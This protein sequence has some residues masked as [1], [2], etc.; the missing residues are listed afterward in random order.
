MKDRLEGVGRIR[1]L[2]VVASIAG[3]G[4]FA[5][6]QP[7]LDL[8]G[9]NPEF[10]IARR[11]PA[12]DIVLLAVGLLIVPVV[13]ALPVLA[14]RRVSGMVSGL[15][16]LAV[17]AVTAAVAAATVLATLGVGEWPPLL[18]GLV[19]GGLG[20][21]TALL[22]MRFSPVRTGLSYL[23]LA[24]VA[25]GL[26]FA[27]AT[28]IS[29]LLFVGPADLPE[30]VAV[31][32]PAPVVMVVFD[33]F[34]LAS[35]VRP[36]GRLDSEHYPNLSRLATAGV[37]Y[38]N[39]V[40]VRQQTEEGLP[41]IIT[42]RAVSEGSIPTTSD[43]PFTMFSLLS[44]AYDIAAVEN[45]TELCPTFVCS[46][47]SRPVD[48]AGER[49]SELMDDLAV[50]YGH[51]V[52]P[53]DLAASLPPVD[54]GWGGFDQRPAGDFD[55]IERFLDEVSEDRR[56]ELDRFLATFDDLGAKP[57]LRF[58]HFLYPH[59]PWDLT[60]DGRVHGA[61]RPPGRDGV[62]WG[63][64]P[65]L[66]AQGWQR[67]L[68]QAHWADTMVGRLIDK[69]E[70]EGI[71]DDALVML[72]ADHG[73]TIRPNAEHQ[74]VVTTETMGSIAW[75]PLFV[76]Y[77]AATEGA[78]PPGSIDDLRAE[79]TDLVPTVAD[80]VDAA[81]PWSMDGVSLLDGQT[82]EQR[83]SSVILGSRGEVEIPLDPAPVLEVV[84]AQESWFPGGDPYRLTP[85][86]WGA[87]LGHTGVTGVED[88]DLVISLYQAE[89]ITGYIA[90][91]DPIPS[92]VSGRV[93]GPDRG[94]Q[95]LAVVADGVVV[96]VTSSYVEDEVVKWEAFIEPA[97]LDGGV[98]EVSV[99]RVSGS[100][101]APIFEG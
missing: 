90:G 66:V 70:A 44:G 78:P 52:L 43:H 47:V 72:V 9:R 101:E 26:W 99:W 35:I 85:S 29:Q 42:G 97:V 41:A 56:R 75:V 50:V 91:T 1:P 34:P 45:V 15:S 82:R 23:G 96:A 83:E 93:D 38:R 100:S 30:A 31:G 14:L 11:F 51:I 54:Q 18:F 24:P 60:A 40:G 86:G 39:A 49:W 37:W 55:I 67:H 79:T 69:L 87:L 25:F 74:R 57:P 98:D 63:A 27:L 32:N 12:P 84:E 20:A 4:A 5:L 81:V 3:V 76:K 65:F 77:P 95:T 17:L 13:L 68:I 8:L 19:C 46:N 7:L 2:L 53:A 22:Y 61:P 58:A 33:E 89:A 92:Y 6:G 94:D 28:P 80:V 59:H 62:G 64:D 71:Y 36:D 21:G 48:P 88:P 73:I 10:F 16:H